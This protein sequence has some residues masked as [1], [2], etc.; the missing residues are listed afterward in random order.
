MTLSEIMSTLER[1]GAAPLKSLGQNFLHDQNLARWIV[2][3]LELRPGEHAVEIGPGLGALSGHL[4]QAGVSATLIEKDSAYA[5][6]L[7]EKF[8]PAGFEVIAGDALDHDPRRFFARRPVKLLGMLPYYASSALLLHFT[9]EPCPFSRVIVTIQKEVAERI[10]SRP[11]S[12]SYGSLS[13]VLQRRWHVTKLRTLPA[14]VFVPQPQVDSTVVLMTPRQGAE[15]LPVDADRFEALIRLGF[16]ERRKQLRKL[17]ATVYAPARLERAWAQLGLPIDIRA[18]TLSV[19]DWINLCNALTDR[20]PE[21]GTPAELL[22]VVDAA[23]NPAGGV[24]RATVHAEK[25][26]HRAVH[27]LMVN[28]CGELFLQRRSCVKDRYPGRWDSSAAGHVDLGE[29]YV[30]CAHREAIEEL[31][32][33]VELEPV[34]KLPASDMTDQEFVS[35]FC[36]RTDEKP[37][38][39]PLE[40]DAFGAF[41]L[42]IVDEWVERCPEDFAPAFI[43]CYH[44]ARGRLEHF[45]SQPRPAGVISV[46]VDAERSSDDSR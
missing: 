26:L 8:G 39:N 42:S 31:G 30:A 9:R 10:T 27:V 24:D 40:I 29:D 11:G 3:Q 34:G 23:D 16:R 13:V 41:P 4:Q 35:V 46:D 1:L 12:K 17:L 7:R 44:L 19:P 36:G 5:G 6:F 18:E 33:A 15:L 22:Q 21:G 20:R 43:G 28:S 25:R 14:S 2:R 45:L 38:P 32:L 37:S